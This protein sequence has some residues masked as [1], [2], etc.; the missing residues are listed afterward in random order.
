MFQPIFP[1]GDA[2]E[3]PPNIKSGC[4]GM[5]KNR[6]GAEEDK[7]RGNLNNSDTNGND[8]T[9][10]AKYWALKIQFPQFSQVLNEYCHPEVSKSECPDF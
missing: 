8:I 6:R 5:K 1:R 4:T 9:A 10:I 7:K 2:P 3:E